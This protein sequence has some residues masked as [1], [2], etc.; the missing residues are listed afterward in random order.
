MFAW[1]S[2]PESWIALAT[3]I[4]LEIVLGID[5]VIFISILTGRL[6]ATQRNRGRQLGLV[7]AMVTRLALLFGIVWIS[8]L[9]TPWF[10]IF[11]NAISG[12]DIILIAGGLFLLGKST[13]EIHSK[14][15]K[16]ETSQNRHQEC[17]L[18]ISAGTDRITGCSIFP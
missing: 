9:V 10:T 12:R 4:A 1:V 5:N 18:S 3:L 16:T 6:P 11:G 2:H 13:Q 14:L 17:K 8:N 7:L 15:T